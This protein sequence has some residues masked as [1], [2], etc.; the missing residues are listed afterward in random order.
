ME[1]SIITYEDRSLKK[2]TIIWLGQFVSLL[3][4]G[5]SAFGLSVWIYI[6]TGSATPFAMSFLCSI[7]PTIIFAPFAGSFADRKKRKV[8]IMMT[9]S[10]DALLKLLMAVLLFF[11][12]MHVWMVYPILFTSAILSTFQGPAFNAS[13]PMLVPGKHLSRANGMLQFSQACQSMLAPILAGALFPIINLSGLLTIDFV[14]FFFAIFTILFVKIPQPELEKEK[15]SMFNTA[16]GDLKFAWNYLIEKKGFI[17]LLVSFSILN[18]IANLSIILIGPL[19]LSNYD[20]SIY[21]TVQAVYGLAMVLGGVLSGILPNTNKKIKTLFM[22]LIISGIGLVIS[23]ISISWYVIALGFFIFM[24][25]VPYANTLLQSLVQMKIEASVLG[26]VGALMSAVLKS[27]TPI[28][29][30]L[31]GPLADNVFEPLMKNDGSIGS[32]FIGSLI[33][34]GPGRGIGLLFILCGIIILNAVCFIM[35]C[36]KQIMSMEKRL[37]DV[38]N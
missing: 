28:A 26:R 11:D 37:P 35:L 38:S 13:I 10:L 22:M 16:M 29:C 23:G 15:K 7:L 25:P 33:G 34:T 31:A 6:K 1:R 19:V 32:N 36:K 4:S 30:I 9:D 20:S 8:I 5:L 14:S 27:I 21:G 12:L 2:F 24:I 17:S 3:G 18:F